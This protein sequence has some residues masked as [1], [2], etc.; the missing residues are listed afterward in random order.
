MEI[1]ITT[2]A[3]RLLR[4][5]RNNIAKLSSK[6][7]A[8]K[9]IEGIIDHINEMEEHPERHPPCR[10]KH[11]KKLGYRCFTHKKTY[12]IVYEV[13]DKIYV[14]GITYARKH[15]DNQFKEILGKD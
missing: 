12:L 3:K 10:N 13:T 15:H 9:Y 5:I 7:V 2:S 11:L 4:K 8:K 14:I 6:D 1:V